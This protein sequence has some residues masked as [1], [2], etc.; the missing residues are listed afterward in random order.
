[1]LKMPA[2]LSLLSCPSDQSLSTARQVLKPPATGALT[3]ELMRSYVSLRRREMAGWL[4]LPAGKS[5]TLSS[6]VLS[7]AALL[8]L[9]R[10]RPLAPAADMETLTAVS[11]VRC[12]EQEG[13]SGQ[14]M[15]ATWRVSVAGP[16]ADVTKC[17][18]SFG[19]IA[20]AG[21]KISSLFSWVYDFADFG[22][23]FTDGFSHDRKEI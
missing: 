8:V 14:G 23:L 18:V 5:R 2:G 6:V 10:R 15:T 16:P 1:M 21:R 4:E 7:G 17:T 19:E 11:R 22:E 3:A 20:T 9:D 13:P 12:G